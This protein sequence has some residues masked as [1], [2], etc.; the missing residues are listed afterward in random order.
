MPKCCSFC[1]KLDGQTPRPS[2]GSRGVMRAG[3][4]WARHKHR[5]RVPDESRQT[6][7]GDATTPAR[8]RHAVVSV[9]RA[10]EQPRPLVS[11]VAAAMPRSLAVLGPKGSG[12]RTANAVA[13]RSQ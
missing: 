6:A 12:L 5:G 3:L 4:L 10:P 7:L 11:L 1:P 8:A 9:C 13:L 2:A